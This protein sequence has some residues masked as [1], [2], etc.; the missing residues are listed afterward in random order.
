MTTNLYLVFVSGEDSI[1]K[2]PS[3]EL[4][5]VGRAHRWLVIHCCQSVADWEGVK[6]VVPDA[7][8]LFLVISLHVFS[9]DRSSY[10]VSVLL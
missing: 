3:E 4:E 6:K 7:P 2:H 1:L 5:V 10:S 8:Y 9:S